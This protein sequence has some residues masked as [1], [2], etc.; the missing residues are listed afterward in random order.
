MKKLPPKTHNQFIVTSFT[1]VGLDRLVPGK[2][3][4]SHMW[5]RY[6]NKNHIISYAYF[7]DATMLHNAVSYDLR[8]WHLDL[9]EKVD[10]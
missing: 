6:I 7:V 10:N 9:D 5:Y 1:L 4:T 3:L 2:W 8:L